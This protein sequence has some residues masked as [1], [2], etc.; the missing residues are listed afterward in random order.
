MFIVERLRAWLNPARRR[1]Q[2]KRALEQ[3]C[4]DEGA[5]RAQARAIAARYFR[6]R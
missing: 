3:A 2:A 5:S 1:A 4:R 6:G